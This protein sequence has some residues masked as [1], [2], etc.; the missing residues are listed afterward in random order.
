MLHQLFELDEENNL[1]TWFSSFLLLNNA[2]I[3][4]LISSTAKTKKRHWQVLAVRFL[5]LAIDEV[6]GLHETFYSSIDDNWTIY[7]APLVLIIGAAYLQ[8]LISLPR[9]TAYWFCLSGF[10]YVGGALGI[11]W[12]A[13]DMDEDSFSYALAVAV[14]EGAEIAGA[15]LFL[16]GNLIYLRTL[17]PVV[18][19]ELR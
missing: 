18:S 1:P 16:S 8:F 7:A 5:L 9:K 12:L 4:W 2:A 19:I 10:L 17:H 15:L 3:S 6:A 14:E 13:Q 11:E